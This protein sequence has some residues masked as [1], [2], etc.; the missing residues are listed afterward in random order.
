MIFGITQADL[1]A[2]TAVMPTVKHS[3][4]CQM[5]DGHTGQ[6]MMKDL[7]VVE[8]GYILDCPSPDHDAVRMLWKEEV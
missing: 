5:V 8:A 1:D 7:N 2:L 6:V 3:Q 4:L